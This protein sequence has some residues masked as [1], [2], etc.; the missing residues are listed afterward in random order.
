MKRRRVN[1]CF[2][3]GAIA[4]VVNDKKRIQEEL[5]NIFSKLKCLEPSSFLKNDIPVDEDKALLL[6]SSRMSFTGVLI[7]KLA[8]DHV[9]RTYSATARGTSTPICFSFVA[10]IM[11][12]MGVPISPTTAQTSCDFLERYC[13]N[14]LTSSFALGDNLWTLT[15]EKDYA[16]NKFI[17]PPV[18]SCLK[19]DEPL[20][21][22]NRPT[23]ATVHGPT[24]P[25]PSSKITLECKDCKTTYG[26]G[27]FTDASGRHF[28]PKGIQSPLIEASNV[29]YMDRNFYKWIPSLG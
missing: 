28:Y 9:P 26:I 10:D 4:G 18:E 11:T 16:Y 29:T 17:S 24:G 12:R 8:L 5:D 19:C 27:H 23:E 2:T 22:H 3:P 25:L 7:L 13:K 15:G 20:R 14:F 21:M 6:L 1:E